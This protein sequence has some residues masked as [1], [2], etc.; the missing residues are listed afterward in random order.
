MP[1]LGFLAT[2]RSAPPSAG[3]FSETDTAF[4]VGFTDQGPANT[5]VLCESI[6]QYEA[7]YGP[8]S[9]TNLLYNSVDVFLRE[10]GQRVYVSRE[11][12]EKAKAALAKLKDSESKETLEVKAKYDGEYANGWKIVITEESTEFALKVN[13][14][15]G[16]VLEEHKKIKSR[17]EASEL[18]YTYIEVKLIGTSTKNPEKGETA[19]AEGTDARS[20]VSTEVKEKEAIGAAL[21]AF[22]K[23]LGPGQV[24]APGQSGTG[25]HAVL[26]SHAATNNRAACLFLAKGSEAEVKEATEVA[27]ALPDAEY[28]APFVGHLKCPGITPGTE[29]EIPADVV[30]A[31]LASRGD[32]TGSPNVAPCG[33][34][35]GLLYCTATDSEYPEGEREVLFNAG[36]NTFYS[37]YGV[38]SLSGWQ[39][40]VPEATSEVYDQFNHVRT[41]M[42]IIA[43]SEYAAAWARYKDI[44]Q[45]LLLGYKKKLAEILDELFRAGAL[46]G[47]ETESA[48]EAYAVNVGPTVNTAASIEKQEVKAILQVRMAPYASF[49][50][51]EIVSV[52]SGSALSE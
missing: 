4:M 51:I 17:K 36:V 28:G 40:L 48:T 44:T 23:G 10:A 14:S 7:V 30:A 11:V 1:K 25:A 15:S 50:P 27:A 46:Y 16:T 22:T 42:A 18:A 34:E 47:G 33:L 19:L 13:S 45:S 26:L 3:N 35:Y 24:L 5:A 31:A 20:E 9:T 52:P 2:T 29:R 43:K 32:A 39:T 37:Q 21:T 12:G 41:R 38:L 6:A 8:S 49:T